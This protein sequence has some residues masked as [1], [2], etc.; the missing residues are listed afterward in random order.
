MARVIVLGAGGLLG[1]HIA[2]ALE[3][4]NEVIRVGRR[5]DGGGRWHVLDVASED[6]RALEQLLV[7]TRPDA[8]INCIGA[9]VGTMDHLV[10]ANTVTAA[11]L[12]DAMVAQ[13]D[14]V[15]L[16][17]LGSAAE[18]GAPAERVPVVETSTAH[19]TSAYGV[20]KLA[21]SQLIL[22]VRRRQGLEAVVLRIF[23]PVGPG[24]PPTTLPGRAAHSMRQ[25]LMM[26]QPE[27]HL[28]PLGAYRDYIDV[29][30]VA[31]AVVACALAPR[32]P[33]ELLNVGSGTA[34]LARALVGT[35][36]AVSGFAGTVVEADPP[37]DRSAAVDWIAA[38]TTVVRRELGWKPS[39]SLRDSLWDQWSATVG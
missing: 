12:L 37:S 22:G 38:D 24:L 28:G 17:H 6:D 39:Y 27:I 30:D 9:T 10:R 2:R 32:T 20:S 21:A 8:I 29:R 15:R 14:Q 36:G 1:G 3:L 23:N 5:A 34:V 11:R 26:G 35:L 33:P 7:D 16:V 13:G 31:S 18:Y 4:E 25:A 19:P